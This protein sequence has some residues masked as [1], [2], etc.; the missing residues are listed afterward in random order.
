MIENILLAIF[1]FLVIY[2]I[3]FL[4]N[5][6]KGLSNLKQVNE[7]KIVSEYVSIIIPFRNEENNLLKN[8]K[9]L[10]Q[11]NYPEDKYEIIYVNDLSTDNSVEILERSKKN[12]NIKII[13]VPDN[14]SP[15]AHKKRAIRY[16]IEHAKGEIIVTTDADCTYNKDWLRA[17]LK[18]MD[19][20][21]AFISGP[22]EFEDSKK[23]FDRLQRTEFAGLVIS[24]AGLIG[25]NRPAICNAANIAYR[26]EAFEKV[27]GF[28]DQLKLSSGDDELLMQKIWKET[29]YKIKFCPDKKAVVK[30]TPNRSLNEFYQQRKRWASKGL[31]YADKLLILKLILIFLFYLSL[32]IQLILG[33]FLSVKF[34]ILFII[35]LLLKAFFEYLVLKKGTVLL[36]DKKLLNLFIFAE[37]LHIPYIIISGISGIFGNFTWKER[38]VS[39]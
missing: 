32:L 34:L 21:T 9:S 16:G 6:H 25:I 37:I 15:N 31:F 4:S 10:E 22:V 2:Y 28:E 19:D 26:K 8:L 14:F 35:S 29:D 18:Y 11:Q 39:R 38:K 5:I 23:L 7:D 24:G 36:F 27:N 30:T 13:S 3:Y 17:L 33:V 12:N 1:T 20:Q